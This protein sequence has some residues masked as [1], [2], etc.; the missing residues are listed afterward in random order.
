MDF[1]TIKEGHFLAKKSEKKCIFCFFLIESK[2]IENEKVLFSQMIK[3]YQKKFQPFKRKKRFLNV[4][5][6][7]PKSQKWP[8]IDFF[9][10]NMKIF[11]A[12]PQSFEETLLFHLV[13][14]S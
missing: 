9:F 13:H 14:F 1:L 7:F 11:F 10:K 3:V 12:T 2:S 4:F 6:I 5:V 8:K